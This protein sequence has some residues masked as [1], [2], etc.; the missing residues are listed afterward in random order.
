MEIPKEYRIKNKIW[1]DPDMY[2]S[3]AWHS[4]GKS[5]SLIN[6]LL[7]CLQKR[8]W[9]YQKRKSKSKKEII[10]INDGFT[11]PYHEAAGLKIAGTT[12]HWKNLRKLVD[13]GFLDPVHQG[14]WYRKHERA[15]DYSVY[16]L[17]DRWR[18]YG[19]PDFERIEM[20]KVLP[21]HFHIRENIRRQ[22]TKLTSLKRR[23]DLHSNE[24]E[25]AM[26][27]NKRLYANEDGKTA[28][29]DR[30]SFAITR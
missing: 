18:K 30:Q 9:E 4:I 22:K 23:H 13:Y 20:P 24:D 10:Y 11:F 17:S 26:T 27:K 3:E 1:I 6:T 28:T 15:K 2:Y 16:K 29:N 12:Q 25:S 19:K 7:R 5:A 8:K 21:K 14:G